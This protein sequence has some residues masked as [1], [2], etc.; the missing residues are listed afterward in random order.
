MMS[1]FIFISSLNN[2]GL[3]QDF[4][5]VEVKR[6]NAGLLIVRS[7]AVNGFT[8][9]KFPIDFSRYMSIESAIEGKIREAIERGEF[10]DLKGKG[11]P[12]DL[13]YFNTPEDLRMACALLR[14]NDFVP[15]EVELMNE[16]SALKERLRLS[17]ND[18]E[19]RNL[20]S[21]IEQK[22]LTLRLNLES[23]RRR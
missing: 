4:R 19:R 9:K 1:L 6:S 20:Q 8:V 22:C 12:L 11:K 21:Y 3:N 10:D 13:N 17:E 16:I 15:A 18:D 5:P 23:R 7:I 2:L 14:S